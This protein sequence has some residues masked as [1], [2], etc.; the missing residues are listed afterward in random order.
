MRAIDRAL[1]VG[2]K[3]ENASDALARI[4][5]NRDRLAGHAEWRLSGPEVDMMILCGI[6]DGLLDGT[7]RREE[8]EQR[9]ATFTCPRCGKERPRN[10]MLCW[11]CGA[12]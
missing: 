2:D 3:R 4:R 11:N 7:V 10:G 9:A 12:K 8:L 6:V 1:T 5:R